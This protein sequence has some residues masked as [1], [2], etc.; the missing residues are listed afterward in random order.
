MD[1]TTPSC[2]PDAAGAEERRFALSVWPRAATRAWRAELC[3]P[4]AAEPLR[5]DRPIDLLIYLTE[6]SGATDDC[7]SGLR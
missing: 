2:N 7:P 3:A 4:L 6:L 5:F 1:D